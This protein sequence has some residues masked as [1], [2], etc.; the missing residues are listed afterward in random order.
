MQASAQLGLIQILE[1]SRYSVYLGYGIPV[2]WSLCVDAVLFILFRKAKVLNFCS[3]AALTAA[4]VLT[5][6]TG[7]RA[8]VCVSPYETNEA[9]IC[10]NN[11]IREN[12]DEAWTICSANDERQ[13]L[14]DYI[15]WK[16]IYC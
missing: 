12:K 1:V 5:A 14:G 8:P 15:P 16:S 11:I 13:M 3:F 10:L 6:K 4:C 7:M 2:V 9:M